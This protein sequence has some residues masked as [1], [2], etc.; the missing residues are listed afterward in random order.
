MRKEGVLERH[1]VSLVCA[2][3]WVVELEAAEPLVL[4]TIFSG[5]RVASWPNPHLH[6]VPCEALCE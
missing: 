2:S 1:R 6:K 5:S 4:N 3:Y